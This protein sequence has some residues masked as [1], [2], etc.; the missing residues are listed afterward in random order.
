MIRTASAIPS[1][2][3]SFS[4][5]PEASGLELRRHTAALARGD[6]VAWEQFH[7][8]YGPAI[9]RQLLAQTRGDHDMAKEA[10]QQTYLR[11]AK[12]VRTCET[13]PQFKAWLRIVA[14]TALHDCW[15]KKQS[16]FSLLLR[17]KQEPLELHEQ[18]TDEHLMVELDRA[19]GRLPET[20]R[21]LLEAKYFVGQDMRTIAE[22]LS[23]STKAVESRLTRA[24][25][26]LRRELQ[27]ALKNHE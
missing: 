17:K 5:K 1:L 9:F 10:L 22:R 6:D 20:D 7:R 19:L 13:K 27:A 24:R 2:P 26:T 3:L 8:D 16:F 14:R 18:D 15:R 12:N 21:T 25:K 23:I 11:I 4:D